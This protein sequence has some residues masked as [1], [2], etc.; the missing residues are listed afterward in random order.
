MNEY[1]SDTNLGTPKST[2]QKIRQCRREKEERAHEVERAEQELGT[3]GVV[4]AEAQEAVNDAEEK[5]AHA[6]LM[7]ERS[8]ANL[9]IVEEKAMVAAA[10][11]MQAIHALRLVDKKLEALAGM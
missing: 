4:V 1:K 3:S 8:R 11:H 10:Q 2:Q 5:F 6:K 9:K 7:L